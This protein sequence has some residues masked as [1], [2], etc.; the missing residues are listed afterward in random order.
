M[1]KILFVF[2]GTIVLIV[3]CHKSEIQTVNDGVSLYAQIEENDRTKTVLDQDGNVLWSED[4]RIVAFM[5]SSLGQQYKITLEGA[6]KTYGRFQRI[7]STGSDD[8]NVGMEWDHNIAYYPYIEDADCRKKDD[9]YTL[10]INLP[11]EQTYVAGSFANGAFPMVAVSEDNNLTFKNICGGIKLQLKG[12]QTVKSITLTGK[13]NEKLSGAAAVT[14]YTD[15]TNPTITMD[16]DALTSVTLNCSEGVQLNERASTEFI[17]TLPPMLFSKGFT[18][19]VTD[20]E[21]Y[22]YTI[23]TDK[24]N[25]ILRSSILYMPSRNL[26]ND[27]YNDNTDIEP[28]VP[29]ES[30]KLN[31]SSLV[32]K[33]AFSYKL[34]ATIIPSDVTNQSIAWSSSNSSIVTIDNS[35]ILTTLSA[36][37][38]NITAEIAG[39]MAS[40]EVKVIPLTKREMIDYAEDGV[41]YGKGIAVGDIIWSPVNCGY[42]SDDYN[43]NNGEFYQWGRRYGQILDDSV[44]IIEG[45]ISISNGQRDIYQNTFFSDLTYPYDWASEFNGQLWNMGSELNPVKTEYDPCPDGWRIP[46]SYELSNLV[47]TS[48]SVSGGVELSGEYTCLDGAPKVYFKR[49]GYRDSHGNAIANTPGVYW[50]SYSEDKGP[51]YL[52]FNAGNAPRIV[53]DGH[54][55][56]GMAIR[57]VQE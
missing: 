11:S 38:V 41:N 42:K 14:A 28:N 12:N 40:C 19:T 31:Q 21:N 3:S 55:T 26:S 18:V 8:L 37:T 50:S 1:Q 29:V 7:T 49:T 16:S 46:T 44:E 24:A 9:A 52:W 10:M 47:I 23:E 48:K 45:P 32:L 5:K 6:G 33:D 2:I 13:N 25:T 17:I 35:G 57:C 56:D 54:R 22:T 20:S 53:S 36:G 34:I 51:N 27:G 43:Y 4:D 15:D 39:M 30:I